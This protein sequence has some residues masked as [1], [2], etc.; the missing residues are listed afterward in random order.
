MECETEALIKVD[1]SDEQDVEEDD[2]EFQ[3]LEPSI[4]DPDHPPRR[5]FKIKS[6]KGGMA[7]DKKTGVKRY[8]SPFE[9]FFNEQEELFKKPAVASV[10]D[11]GAEVTLTTIAST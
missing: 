2:E 8:M 3:D 9:Q 1:A 10:Q 6:T 5:Q 4:I 11:S 7:V